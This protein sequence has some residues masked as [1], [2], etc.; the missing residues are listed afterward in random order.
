LISLSYLHCYIAERGQQ[1]TSAELQKQ[2]LTTT[3]KTEIEVDIQR[4]I[5]AVARE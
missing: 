3:G 4:E 5:Y 1:V 2:S